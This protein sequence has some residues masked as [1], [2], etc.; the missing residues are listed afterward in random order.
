MCTVRKF[1][2]ENN[3]FNVCP[4]RLFLRRTLQ[5]KTVNDHWYDKE[6]IRLKSEQNSLPKRLA[7]ILRKTILITLTD[8]P[9]SVRFAKSGVHDQV[10]IKMIITMPTQPYLNI[11]EELHNKIINSSMCGGNTSSSVSNYHI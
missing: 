10:L 5:W 11:D 3:E 2:V 6:E 9:W 4:V 7:G 1:L 8:R